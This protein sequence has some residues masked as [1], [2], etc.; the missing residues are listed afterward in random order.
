MTPCTQFTISM[1][2]MWT[3][4]TDSPM[5]QNY[6]IALWSLA[7]AEALPLSGGAVRAKGVIIGRPAAQ[8]AWSPMDGVVKFSAGGHPHLSSPPPILCCIVLTD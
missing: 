7:T 3:N 5:C 1:L 4:Y 6:T 2:P 8:P